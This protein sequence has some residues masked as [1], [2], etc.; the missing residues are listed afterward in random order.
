MVRTCVVHI[1]VHVLFMVRTCMSACR[2]VYIHTCCLCLSKGNRTKS[3]YCPYVRRHTVVCKPPPSRSVWI[4]PIHHLVD[5]WSA[6]PY[7]PLLLVNCVGNGSVW[8]PGYIPCTVQ[9]TISS[10]VPYC[11]LPSVYCVGLWL[12]VDGRRR[13]QSCNSWWGLLSARAN[14]CVPFITEAA[15]VCVWINTNSSFHLI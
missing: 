14:N 8:R 11:P 13:L 1:M 7:C 10:V 2:C 5:C 3:L 9:W 15:A 4:H 12:C 6:R